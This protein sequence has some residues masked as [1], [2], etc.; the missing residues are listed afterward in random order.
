MTYDAL[1]ARA[2]GLATRRA[3]A[4]PAAPAAVEAM[5]CDRTETELALLRRWAPDPV[6]TVELDEDRRTLRAIARGI[7]AGI[8]PARRIAGAI[9][10]SSLPRDVL[11]RLAEATSLAAVRV[12]LAGHPLAPAFAEDEL[13]DVECALARRI[14]EQPRPRDAALADYLAQGIDLDNAQIAL[15][16]A[17]RG[18]ELAADALFLPGGRRLARA[19]FVAAAAG[20]DTARAELA[21]AFAGTPVEAA[22]FAAGPSALEDAGLTWQ[23]ASQA[24]WRRLA[25]LGL[26]NLVWWLLQRRDEARRL[27]AAAWSAALGGVA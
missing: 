13:F 25:P 23:L 21:R 22:L 11:A 17:L 14:A 7:V 18:G 1:V 24:R 12:V 6:R 19:R 2:R 26:A 10:T 16:L 9:A 5:L 27:R 15:A 8:A 3:T 20:R 4:V